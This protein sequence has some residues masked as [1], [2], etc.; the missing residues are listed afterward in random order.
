MDHGRDAAAGGG[1]VRAEV[2]HAASRQQDVSEEMSDG[3]WLG[4]EELARLRR[5]DKPSAVKLATRNHWRRRKNNIG[6]MQVFVPIDWLD[7]AQGRWDKYADKSADSAILAAFD[8]ALT[9]LREAKDSEIAT[10]RAAYDQALAQL[11]DASER[12]DRLDAALALQRMRADTL[13]DRLDGMQT[14]LA[15]AEE[16]AR[17]AEEAAKVLQH[18][19][20]ERRARRLLG[21]LKAVWRASSVAT[22]RSRF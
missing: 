22:Q 20:A 6:Q 16:R 2:Q 14:E 15:E 19:E 13:K 12:G 1:Q 10:L 9:A 17:T 8:R 7:R 5:I 3:R 4:Y 21:R 11:A 18:T